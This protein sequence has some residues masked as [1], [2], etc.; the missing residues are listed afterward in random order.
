MLA[1]QL[2]TFCLACLLLS[3]CSLQGCTQSPT[4]PES[5]LLI[6]WDGGRA[7]T[8]SALMVDGTLPSFAALA[9]RG[10]QAEYAQSVDP[11]LTVPA[12]NAIA[13][14][15][16]PART[17]IV[18]NAYHN[19]NDSFYWY[20]RGFQ[21]PLGQADPM[22]VAASRAG[23]TTASLFFVGGTLQQPDQTADYTIGYGERE[24][25][26]RQETIP[27][28]PVSGDWDGEVPISFSI[29]YEGSF[30]IWGVTRVHL[31]V[32]DSRDDSQ[33]I[34]DTVLL[35]TSRQVDEKT[36]RLKVGGWGSLVLLPETVSGADFL[37][38][39]IHQDLAPYEVTLYHSTVYRNSASPRQLLEALNEKF[40]FFPA[41]ADYYALDHGWITPEDNLYRLER[42]SLW[43]AEVTAWVKQTYQP[44]LL[45]TWQDGF[46]TTGHLFWLHD[47]RQP[48]YTLENVQRYLDYYWRALGIA[49]KALDIML[50]SVDLERE[51]VLM[52]SDHGMAPIHT[53]VY[54]NTV[55]EEAGLLTLDW[56]NY[57]VVEES[58]AFAVASGGA[59]NVYINL[60]GHEKDGIVTPEEYPQVQEQIVEL[61]SSL[62]DPERG[63]KVFQRVLH[64]DELQALHLDHLNSGDVFAQANPGYTLNGWRGNDFV[65]EPAD[66]LGQ[67]GY[68]SSLPEMHAIF[69]AAGAGVPSG[70]QVI[71]P[72]HITDYAPTIAAMLGF[73]LAPAVDGKVIPA[74]AQGR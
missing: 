64:Q 30:T 32:L 72:V 59:V 4:Q 39:E 24:A 49:D 67:H 21:E 15:C 58:K 48:G 51:A 46:D 37:I 17:G 53:S 2:K 35:N 63:E 34:Y 26:S 66:Q 41:G 12:Q 62:T 54:V 55:L 27:L 60:E 6:S 56:R 16:F 22:W 44:D 42:A 69:V 11:S 65:F 25:Y 33:P 74:L 28:E 1:R 14:G 7:D 71:P 70:G 47:P 10:L 61:F 13:T 52:V 3:S 8:V 19:P 20:R 31:Y 45:F 29:P 23:L 43:M 38:Q 68:D 18:S 9:A 5:I 57:L 36:P 73:P 40:G 50:E